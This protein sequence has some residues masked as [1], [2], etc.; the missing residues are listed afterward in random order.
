MNEGKKFG[1]DSVLSFLSRLTDVFVLNL[2]WLLC[3]LPVITSGA[4]TS[5]AYAVA[6]KQA[7]DE[8]ST[9]V[10]SFFHHF[11]QNFKQATVLGLL[12]L[13]ALAVSLLDCY[14]GVYSGAGWAR[15]FL[16]LGMTGLLLL[17]LISCFVW[18]LTARYTYS[19]GQLF[20]TAVGMLALC[21]RQ[22]FLIWAIW[23]VPVALTALFPLEALQYFGWAWLIL[24]VGGLITLAAYPARRA[25]DKLEEKRE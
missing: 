10:K 14:I 25:F 18:P 9:P 24:G 6:L 5:A 3:S 8:E 23:M 15:L 13:A 2:L 11:K 20:R 22:A 21:R 4:A 19:F 17:S 12:A 16:F 1:T 7:R